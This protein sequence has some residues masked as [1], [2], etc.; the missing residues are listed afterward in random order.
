[1][2]FSQADPIAKMINQLALLCNCF[3]LPLFYQHFFIDLINP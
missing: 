3:A 1:M 2:I